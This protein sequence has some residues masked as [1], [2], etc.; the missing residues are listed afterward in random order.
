M[1]EICGAYLSYSGTYKNGSSIATR[2]DKWSTRYFSNKH[3]HINERQEKDVGL[4]S[5][6]R[7]G[8]TF[9]ERDEI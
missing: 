4:S 1:M 3:H 2:R 7:S 6:F 5:S 8:N 9:A